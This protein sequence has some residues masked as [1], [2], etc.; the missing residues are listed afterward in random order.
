MTTARDMNPGVDFSALRTGRRKRRAAPVGTATRKPR[1]SE[2]PDWTTRC[3]AA[4][5]AR[6]EPLGAYC[7][8]FARMA[9]V[10]KDVPPLD[11]AKPFGFR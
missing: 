4:D 1:P 3:T 8:S 9:G 6:G 10:K 5:L 2:S 11:T 7:V